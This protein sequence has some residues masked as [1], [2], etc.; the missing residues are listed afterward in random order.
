MTKNIIFAN[1][2]FIK[3]KRGIFLLLACF[4]INYLPAQDVYQKFY[5][6]DG[7]LSSEGY[8]NNGKTTGY[9]KSY[10]HNGMLRS[11]GNRK[12]F[13][14]D[15]LWKFYNTEGELASE[16]TYKEGLKH[17]INRVYEACYIQ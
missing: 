4:L 1:R 3:V 11:E 5:Y 9:W 10:Y 14:L 8:M 17:G 6:Q 12:D 7:T 15:S 13:L 16:I 2:I